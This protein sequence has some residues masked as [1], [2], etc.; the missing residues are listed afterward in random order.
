[1]LR[2]IDLTAKLLDSGA[3]PLEDGARVRV[4]GGG[5]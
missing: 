5:R 1:V 4:E 3:T 2:G